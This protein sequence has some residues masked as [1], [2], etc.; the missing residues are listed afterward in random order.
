MR[1]T[2]SASAAAAVAAAFAGVLMMGSAPAH[3]HHDRRPTICRI[4]HD[5]RAHHPRYYDFHPADRYYRAGPYRADR[6]FDRYDRRFDRYARYDDRRRVRRGR[7]VVFRNVIPARGRARIVVVEEVVFNRNGR[8]RVCTVSA[9]RP[10]AGFISNRR[11][12]RVAHN[13]CSRRAR[14]RV[15]V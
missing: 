7:Q 14:I 1:S 12:R 15:V 4:D 3:A 6:R 9:R 5:H 10:D 11:L 8:R 2:R 13:Q